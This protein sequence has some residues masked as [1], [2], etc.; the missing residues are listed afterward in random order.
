LRAHVKD[1]QTALAA[2]AILQCAGRGVRLGLHDQ[3]HLGPEL[4]SQELRGH[5]PR[6]DVCR[7]EHHATLLERVAQV[8]LAVHGGTRHGVF[9]LRTHGLCKAGGIIGER[10]ERLELL[11]HRP[12]PPADQPQI[13]HHSLTHIR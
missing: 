4:R 13:L 2:P 5:L 1:A 12:T 11:A 10:L 3:H 7:H 8:L 9:A 6:P